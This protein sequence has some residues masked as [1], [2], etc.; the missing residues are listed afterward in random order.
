MVMHPDGVRAAE[1]YWAYHALAMAVMA[2]VAALTYRYF[3]RRPGWRYVAGLALL[4][5]ECSEIGYAASRGLWGYERIVF[6][7]IINFT[8]SGAWVWMLHTA[9]VFAAGTLLYWRRS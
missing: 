2:G 9:R 7:D 8:I 5:W 1:G 3:R 6:A 4:M